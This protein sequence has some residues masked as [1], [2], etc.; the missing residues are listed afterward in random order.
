M[1]EIGE[2]G[3]RHHPTFV[4]SQADK[5]VGH[6]NG[7]GQH[8]ENIERPGLQSFSQPSPIGPDRADE[9][10]EYGDNENVPGL[11]MQEQQN[12]NDKNGLNGV[13]VLRPRQYHHGPGVKHHNPQ[14][15]PAESAKKTVIDGRP[16]AAVLEI[17]DTQHDQGGDGHSD[18]SRSAPNQRRR[19]QKREN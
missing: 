13:Q 14:K 11:E 8:A 18:P 9:K 15:K 1:G 12:G 5:V 7:I 3:K 19:G 16:Q 17:N 10:H 6:V 2:L 4:E